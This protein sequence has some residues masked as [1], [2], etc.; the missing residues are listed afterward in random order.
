MHH[1]EEYHDHFYT[2]SKE[3]SDNMIPLGWEF[4]GVEFYIMVDEFA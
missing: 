3:E 2:V 4:E 1:N